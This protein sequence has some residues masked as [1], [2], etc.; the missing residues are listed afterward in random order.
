M[1]CKIVRTKL[2]I[3]KS[4]WVPSR[5]WLA[6][7]VN[8]DGSTSAWAWDYKTRKSLVQHIKACAPNAVII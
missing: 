5:P 3:S 1:I 4:D 2:K 8:V 6:S 7:I